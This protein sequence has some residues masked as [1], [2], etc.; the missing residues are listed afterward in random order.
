MRNIK[1]LFVLVLALALSICTFGTATA[2]MSG[3]T[4]LTYFCH[5]EVW[6]TPDP[7]MGGNSPLVYSGDTGNIPS[8]EEMQTSYASDN[9]G[10]GWSGAMYAVDAASGEMIY[11]ECAAGSFPG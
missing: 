9:P 8:N 2:Q 10:G 11:I 6:G 5:I 3:G 1:N 7:G 4:T